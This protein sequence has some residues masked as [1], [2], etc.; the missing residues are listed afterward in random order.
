M[1]LVV[2]P[3]PV[4]GGVVAHEDRPTI[5][6]L[7][8]LFKGEEHLSDFV[9]RTP[10]KWLDMSILSLEELA[11]ERFLRL[12]LYCPELAHTTYNRAGAEGFDIHE[13]ERH[14][15]SSIVSV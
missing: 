10:F 15:S 7:K 14:Q 8:P 2:N 6:L 9:I 3:L 12:E 13:D 11:V 4:I 5:K 1:E